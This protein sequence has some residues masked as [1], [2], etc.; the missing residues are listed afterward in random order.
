MYCATSLVREPC[1]EECEYYEPARNNL[2]F[3]HI[4]IKMKSMSL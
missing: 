3:I 4:I 1:G 2:F